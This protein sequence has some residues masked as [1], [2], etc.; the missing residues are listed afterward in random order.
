MKRNW[1]L[2][3][4]QLKGI[5]EEYNQLADILDKS[6]WS[7]ETEREKEEVRQL[8]H[9]RLLIDEGLVEGIHV[10]QGINGHF[11]FSIANSRMTIAGHDILENLRSTKLWEKTKSLAIKNG[12]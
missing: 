3:R 7:N 1:D 2:L 8:Y 9:L 5:E 11:T 10:G 6:K 4:K 12:I